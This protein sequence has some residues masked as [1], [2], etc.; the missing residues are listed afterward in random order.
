MKFMYDPIMRVLTVLEILQARDHV[1]GRELALR[2]EVHLRTVQRYIARLQDL[3]VPVESMRGAGGF[4]RLKPGFRLPPLM[5]TD[6]EAFAVALGL[7]GLRHLGLS[8]FAPA[9]EGAAAKLARVLPKPLRSSIQMMEEV[10]ALEPGPWVVSTSAESLICV[11]T[12]IRGKRRLTFGYQSHAGTSSQREIEPYG[13]AH[14]DGRWYMVG[15]CLLRQ[16]LRTFRLD[17]VS[18]PEIGEER[19]EPAADFDIKA[20]L[21]KGM[22]FVQSTFAIEVWVDLP[23]AATRSHFALHRVSM[24]EENGGTMLRCGRD[25]LEAFAAMLLSLGCRIVVRE[26]PELRE[27]FAT[28][29]RR[30]NDAA[31]PA[32]LN[33]PENV[34]N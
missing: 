25:N 16:D 1:S 31:G 24:C 32:N 2:L 19:F 27:M 10:V 14:M 3:C 20:Y 5:F 7:R 23:A 4:Y 21:N 18:Q 6:E 12:A 17:R 26:P 15:R 29:A 13:V 33:S 28:L 22:P 30:A 34:R 9:T 8:A 11:S